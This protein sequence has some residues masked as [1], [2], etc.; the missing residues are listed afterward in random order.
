[1]FVILSSSASYYRFVVLDDYLVSYEGECDPYTQVCFVG[2]EDDECTSE[3]YYSL[4]EKYAPNVF[5]QCGKDI[6][7]CENAYVCLPE[8][9]EKCAITFC[10]PESGADA[11]EEL[12]EEDYIEEEEEEEGEVE[13]DS[14]E[15]SDATSENEEVGPDGEDTVETGGLDNSETNEIIESL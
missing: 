10:D 7:D 1:M 9:G 12:T 13:G 15:Y 8:D 6:T 14:M 4:M 5:E 3:Y 11:C 2:C